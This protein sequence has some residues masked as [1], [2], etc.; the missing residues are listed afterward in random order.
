VIVGGSVYVEKMVITQVQKRVK[1]GGSVQGAAEGPVDQDGPAVS[2]PGAYI[3]GIKD[4]HNVAQGEEK[5]IGGQKDGS[6]GRCVDTVEI[7]GDAVAGHQKKAGHQKA[8]LVE[9]A[10]VGPVIRVFYERE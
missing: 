1:H 2:E 8:R 7:P 6:G 10:P 5:G 9:P 3:A 4:A